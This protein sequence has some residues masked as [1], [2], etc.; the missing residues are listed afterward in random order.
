MVISP[1]KVGILKFPVFSCWEL[2]T[3]L[4]GANHRKTSFAEN[5]GRGIWLSGDDFYCS[6]RKP[7]IGDQHRPAG[8]DQTVPQKLKGKGNATPQP[9][10]L[11]TTEPYQAKLFPSVRHTT[12]ELHSTSSLRSCQQDKER[13]L[14]AML[15]LQEKNGATGNRSRN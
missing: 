11:P 15:C 8:E 13:M 5:W 6:W 7:G 3:D 12:E 10:A 2:E 4:K 9:R 14:N 1:G